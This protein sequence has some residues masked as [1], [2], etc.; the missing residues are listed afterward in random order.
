MLS[1]NRMHQGTMAGYSLGQL[2]KLSPTSEKIGTRLVDHR[3]SESKAWWQV[4][5]LSE[6]ASLKEE[7]ADDETSSH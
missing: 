3:A 4:F 2:I 5:S 1:N 7:L 6:L